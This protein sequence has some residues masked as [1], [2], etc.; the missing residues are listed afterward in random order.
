MKKYNWKHV[1]CFGF[2]LTFAL[3]IFA[4]CVQEEMTEEKQEEVVESSEETLDDYK[5]ELDKLAEDILYRMKSYD[6]WEEVLTEEE[7][8]ALSYYEMSEDGKGILFIE[9][10]DG[11]HTTAFTDMYCSHDGVNWEKMNPEPYDFDEILE[12]IHVNERIMVYSC[13]GN[14]MAGYH[15][16]MHVSEDLGR[17]FQ[18][19]NPYDMVQIGEVNDFLMDIVVKE[20]DAERE[21]IVLDWVPAMEEGAP[22]FLTAE[23]DMKARFLE[24]RYRLEEFYEVIDW[25]QGETTLVFTD[26]DRR[27]LTRREIEEYIL[28][29]DMY[30]DA[31]PSD[32]TAKEFLSH[33]INAIYARKGME[34]SEEAQKHFSK[35]E[36]NNV[37]LLAEY[38]DWLEEE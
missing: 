34:S 38:R 25:K 13:H 14:N 8:E 35:Y 12:V 29:C 24:E 28:A 17:T 20:V 22:V 5:Q 2:I 3:M 16:V 11:A 23:Y 26:S 4:A 9:Y 37:D 30:D 10:F 31:Y 33:E 21:T 32:D 7:R 27:N 6:K 36:Q 19:V 1:L 15:N 18:D